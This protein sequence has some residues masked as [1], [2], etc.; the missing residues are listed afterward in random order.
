[1]TLT[2]VLL[3]KYR[4][5]SC[6]YC[7][8]VKS[9]LCIVCESFLVKLTF[10]EVHDRKETNVLHRVSFWIYIKIKSI[11]SKII[12]LLY[13]FYKLI[14]LYLKVFKFHLFFQVCAKSLKNNYRVA[15]TNMACNAS[16]RSVI[17]TNTSCW[18]N[19]WTI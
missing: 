3:N 19:V 15:M 12:Y 2:F 17:I 5:C 18:N 16:L 13:I 10:V 4:F 9:F 8:R 7:S 1:V 14:V 11:E 6:W